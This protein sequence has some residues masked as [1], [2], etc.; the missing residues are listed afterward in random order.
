MGIQ[1]RWQHYYCVHSTT[2]S[3]P[4]LVS[5]WLR[6]VSD[7]GSG[8]R[9]TEACSTCLISHWP[10]LGT[11]ARGFAQSSRGSAQDAAS[12][13]RG[14]TAVVLRTEKLRETEGVSSQDESKRCNPR[15]PPHSHPFLNRA[16]GGLTRFPA[17]RSSPGQCVPSIHALPSLGNMT[18]AFGELQPRHSGRR[19]TSLLRGCDFL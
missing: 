15:Q 1:T 3:H 12:P 18:G 19:V 4:R 16:E 13:T 7:Q 6:A 10:R 8:K 14:H 2:S 9:E 11:G 5:V 17:S